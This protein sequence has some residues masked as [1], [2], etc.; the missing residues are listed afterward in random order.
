MSVSVWDMGLGRH[1]PRTELCVY[2]C[3]LEAIQNSMKHAGP[4]ANVTIRLLERPDGVGFSL[5]DDGMGFVPEA[6]VPGS[7]LHNIRER[8]E[9]LGGEVHISS[10][11]GRGAVIRGFVPDRAGSL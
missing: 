2:Y 3:A 9:A 6:V 7:G 1:P 8:I 4:G 10:A 5:E 11:P